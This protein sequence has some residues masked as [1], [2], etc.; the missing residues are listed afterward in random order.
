MPYWFW[1]VCMSQSFSGCQSSVT[2]MRPS[3]TSV[4]RNGLL[5]NSLTVSSPSL[6][7]ARRAY[8]A[9]GSTPSRAVLNVICQLRTDV[10]TLTWLM[11]AP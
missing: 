6:T 9:S 8:V 11:R 4:P 1:G 3:A 7:C 2:A 10:S 5:V